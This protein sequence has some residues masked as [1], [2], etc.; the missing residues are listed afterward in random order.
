MEGADVLPALLH[1]GDEEV[2][3]HGDV[4]PD[5]LFGLL[6]GGD[7]GAHAVDL[8]ALELDILLQLLQL[9]H[10]LLALDQVDGETL[11]LDQHVAEQF[12]DLLSDVVG[13]QQ[14]V[15]LLCPLLDL[16]LVLVEGLEPV[17]IDPGDAL[18]LSLFHVDGVGEDADLRGRGGTLTFLW[19]SWGRRTLP[20]NLLSGS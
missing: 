20:L 14:H 18:G 1:E 8:L 7:G 3:G 11:H 9:R 5:L 13:G 2:D 15:E 6:D 4:L 17:D 16:C 10:D 19:A 12:V